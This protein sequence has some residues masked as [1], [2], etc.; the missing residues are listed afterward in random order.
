MK[1]KDFRAT[2]DRYLDNELSAEARG[3]L[4]AHL[5]GCAGCRAELE[6]QRKLGAVLRAAVQ[7]AEPPPGLAQRSARAALAA[8]RQ[9]AQRPSLLDRLLPVAW[10]TAL[11]SA[12]AAMLLWF[13]VPTPP[14][15]DSG[16]GGAVESA[17][18]GLVTGASETA[19]LTVATELMAATLGDDGWQEVSP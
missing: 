19:E 9:T 13:A 1:C 7:K 14:P 18:L 8:S 10:P 12:A 11:A 5:L 3:P 6:H 15:A 17:S 4:E 16:W 2:L